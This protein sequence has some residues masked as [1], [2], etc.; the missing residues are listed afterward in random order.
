MKPP[1]APRS[2]VEMDQVDELLDELVTA[3]NGAARRMVL[4]SADQADVSTALVVCERPRCHELAPRRLQ[5]MV[6]HVV[7]TEIARGWP[8]PPG[9]P[10]HSPG[11]IR[12]AT[13]VEYATFTDETE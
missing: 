2:A 5:D 13:G 12:R 7:R 1:R 10:L 11:D 6:R 9:P 8:P 4:I 3:T